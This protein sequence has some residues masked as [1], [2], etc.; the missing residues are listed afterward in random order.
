MTE[1]LIGDEVDR[2]SPANI[3]TAW[4]AAFDG[5]L[6]SADLDAVAGLFHPDGWWRD[7]LSFG[8]DLRTLHGRAAIADHLGDVLSAVGS[9]RFTPSGPD[10]A[11][12]ID[13]PG[14]RRWVQA[15]FDFETGVARGHGIVRLTPVEGT[16][17]WRAWTL[18]TSMVELKG[19]E[20][21]NGPRRPIGFHH[22]PNRE[23]TTWPQLRAAAREYVDHDPQ[24]VILGAGQSGLALAARLGQLGIDTLVVET[25]DRVGDNWRKRY[26]SL[27]L[28][29][30]IWGNHLP[31]LPFPSTWPVFIPKDKLAD[32]FEFYVST[33]ELNVWTG[34]RLTAAVHDPES[35]QWTLTVRR[36]DGSMR[37]LRPAHLVLATG[38]SG[39]PRRPTIAG[40]DEFRGELLHSSEVDTSPPRDGASILI[41]GAGNSAHDIAHDLVE[42]GAAGDDGAAV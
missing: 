26:P 10:G 19:F 8:W 9:T 14:G 12:I 42:Q 31:Y 6:G 7:Q 28:H 30:P 5:A 35:H 33:L 2:Q 23:Q 41:V 38:L 29:D 17:D 36:S 20:E 32:W 21:F 27:F 1:V 39:R 15:R 22:G 3:A 4:L 11:S 40:E 16:D 13:G 24:V 18:F 25:N 34:T 37:E